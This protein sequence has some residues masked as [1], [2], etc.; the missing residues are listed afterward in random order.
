M[1]KGANDNRNKMMLHNGSASVTADLFGGA[2]TRFRLDKIDMNPLSFS[3]SPEEMPEN[4]QPGAPYRGHFLCLGRWGPPSEGER[5]AGMP[6]HGQFANMLWQGYTVRD[7]SVIRMQ[8]DS[9]LEE[10]SIRREIIL[11]EREAVYGVK[12]VVKNEYGRG[13]LYNMVQHPTLAFPFLD[14]D[15][16]VNCNASYGFD[17]FRSGHPERRALQW[18]AGTDGKGRPVDLRRPDKK[19]N[20]VFSFIVDRGSEYGWITAFNPRRRLLLGYLWRRSDYPWIHLWQH[21]E[22]DRIK[23]RGIEFGTAGIHQPFKKILETGVQ[24]FGEKTVEY[25]DA[26]ESVGRNYLSFLLEMA[27]DGGGV[28]QVKIDPESG[29]ILIKTPSGSTRI[30]TIFKNF[31]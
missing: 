8:A 22:E 14:G 18:P 10:L 25:I 16:L 11:D 20:S 6:D 3:F 29:H 2:I 5:L 19:Y 13:R 15:T 27:G 17:Q 1:E 26:G 30:K 12:E 24:L 31:L 23:Y 7:Q 21:W 28:E 4:N 9:S